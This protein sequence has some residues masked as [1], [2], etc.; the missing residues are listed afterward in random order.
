MKIP[1][2]TAIEH[3]QYEFCDL[4]CLRRQYGRRECQCEAKR[5]TIDEINNSLL[6]IQEEFKDKT[7]HYYYPSVTELKEHERRYA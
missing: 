4:S 7:G 3:L 2:K 6:D 1:I 5:Q